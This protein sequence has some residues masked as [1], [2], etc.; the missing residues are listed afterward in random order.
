MGKGVPG[1]R[2]STYKDLESRTSLVC[3]REDKQAAGAKLQRKQK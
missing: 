1:R 2:N 3:W